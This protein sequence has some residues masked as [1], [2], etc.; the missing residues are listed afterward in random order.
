MDTEDAYRKVQGP[1]DLAGYTGIKGVDRPNNNFRH[2]IS[3]IRSAA[4][5]TYLIFFSSFW[6]FSLHVK[7]WI[8]FLKSERLND[9]Y[10]NKYLCC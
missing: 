7:E 6:R 10:L 9:L 4:L 1:L 3:D 2:L 8:Y 5:F